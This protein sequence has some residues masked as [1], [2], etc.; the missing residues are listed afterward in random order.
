MLDLLV[1]TMFGA[2]PSR[3]KGGS[4]RHLGKASAKTQ[5]L[6]NPLIKEYALNDNRIPNLI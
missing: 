5:R 4:K 6:Q 1:Q 2:A 3:G